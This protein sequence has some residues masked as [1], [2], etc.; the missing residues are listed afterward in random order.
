MSD[1]NIGLRWKGGLKESDKIQILRENF[2][3][4]K[5]EVKLRQDLVRTDSK[6]PHRED[7]DDSILKSFA[8]QLLVILIL[9][10]LN[11]LRGK[12]NTSSVPHDDCCQWY[13]EK[14]NPPAVLEQQQ[15]H[16]D[17]RCTSW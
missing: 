10:H 2:R 15:Q 6:Y 12:T 1:F 17:K 11:A 9:R 3:K 16:R 7:C 13:R 5:M 14:M 4:S 8:P